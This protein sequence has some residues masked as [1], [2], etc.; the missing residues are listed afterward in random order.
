[1]PPPADWPTIADILRYLT[2]GLL[3]VGAGAPLARASDVQVRSARRPLHVSDEP[4]E[5]YHLIGIGRPVQAVVR[6]PGRLDVGFR[7]QAPANDSGRAHVR[8]LVDDVELLRLDLEG[9]GTAKFV[10]HRGTYPGKRVDR[11]VRIGE[12]KHTVTISTQGGAAAA[13]FVFEREGENPLAVAPLAPEPLAATPLSAAPLTAAPLAAGPLTGE[14]EAAPL[15]TPPPA[16]AARTVAAT[17]PS[18]PSAAVQEEKKVEGPRARSTVPFYLLGGSVLVGAGAL[19]ALALANGAYGSYKATP[20]LQGGSPTNRAQLLSQA[21]A[22]ATWAQA[23]G[24]VAVAALASAALVW[25]F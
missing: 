12:G 17:E 3:L 13:T 2:C 19:T 21:N 24:I 22:D 8:V 7:V 1:M 18:A 5:L 14:L 9:P 11:R 10:G 4:G 6:G 23:L 25:S 16:T 20:E 15:G